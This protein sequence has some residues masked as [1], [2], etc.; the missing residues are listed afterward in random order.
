VMSTVHADKFTG[1][2]RGIRV[3]WALM[4]SM[5][6]LVPEGIGEANLDVSESD[7]GF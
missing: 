5:M 7:S 4:K 6:S 1:V 2:I 3:S